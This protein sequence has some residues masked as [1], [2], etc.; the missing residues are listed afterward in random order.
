MKPLRCIVVDDEPLARKGMQE[1]IA[2][3]DF[4][5]IA[6]AFENA[7]QA[8][9][10]LD[11]LD[12][13]LVF[14]DIEMPGISGIDFMRTLA[15][16]PLVIFTTAYPDYALQGYELD[17]VDYLLK[18]VSL[19]RFLKAVGKAK[20]LYAAKLTVKG[21]GQV[22]NDY[23][24]VKESGK[25]VK[26]FYKEVLYAEALQNYVSI[27]LEDR[28]LITYITLSTLEKQFPVSSFLRIHKSY[29]VALDKI[30]GIEG[31]SVNIRSA[32]IPISR[33][34]KERLMQCVVEKKLLKR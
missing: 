31:G 21:Q 22:E 32:L 8:Y 3:V 10:A 34:V 23:F 24:F 26:I 12:V 9:P 4:L 33:N 1:Y 7:K 17:V 16:P 27:H 29:I 2:Q 28:K 30:D 5:E 15:N 13:D 19:P 20:D 14:L 25:F 6:G 18:P 11:K